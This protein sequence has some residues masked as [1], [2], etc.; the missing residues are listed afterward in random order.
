MFTKRIQGVAPLD[1]DD[2]LLAVI[3]RQSDPSTRPDPRGSFRIAIV[4]VE[5]QIYRT[6][7]GDDLSEFVD[8]RNALSEAG[9]TDYYAIDL[10]E[11]ASFDAILQR[12]AGRVA[13]PIDA[14]RKDSRHRVNDR[15]NR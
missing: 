4:N 11:S 14:P 10:T 6:L 13:P 9:L 5:G 2:E 1:E 3:Q 7:C 8:T 15:E 12:G